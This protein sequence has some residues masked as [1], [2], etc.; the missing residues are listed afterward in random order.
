MFFL[1]ISCYP[2]REVYGDDIVCLSVHKNLGTLAAQTSL[3]QTSN[4]TRIKNNNRR[5][6]KPFAYKVMTIYISHNNTFKVVIL[7][8]LVQRGSTTPT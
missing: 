4:Y 5:L 8:L 7:Q 3:W 2:R 6:L 1:N